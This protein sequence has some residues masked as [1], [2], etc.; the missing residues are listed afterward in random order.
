[1]AM[2]TRLSLVL[3]AMLT[4]LVACES[5]APRG[6]ADGWSGTPLPSLD[7]LEC[8]WQSEERV[9]LHHDDREFV[10]LT[11]IARQPNLLTV[12]V[13]DGLGHRQLALTRDDNGTQLLGEPPPWVARVSNMMLVGIFL[14]YQTSDTWTDGDATLEFVRNGQRKVLRSV[15]YELASLDYMNGESGDKRIFRISGE[16]S[17]LEITTLSHNPLQ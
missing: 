7:V 9:T 5:I 17:V 10:F 11:V 3:L 13:L 16:P 12:V 1:M 6:P 4:F 2:N 8:C 15:D 14:H